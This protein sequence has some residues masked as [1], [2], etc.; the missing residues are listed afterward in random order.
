MDENTAKG[1]DPDYVAREIIDNIILENEEVFIARYWSK[2]K[3][4]SYDTF[5]IF[6]QRN[7]KT[8]TFKHFFTYRAHHVLFIYLRRLLPTFTMRIVEARAIKGFS[9]KLRY[10]IDN[11]FA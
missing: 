1:Y 3:L 11:L 8:I 10:M 4:L 6:V 5:H 9:T 2:N 7:L